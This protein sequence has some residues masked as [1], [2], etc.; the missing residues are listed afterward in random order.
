MIELIDV[1]AAP[2][3][4]TCFTTRAGGVSTGPW[5]GLNLGAATG[6]DPADVRENR[7]RLSAALG[8]DPDS[9]AL[10]RQVHGTDVL[11]V[12]VPTLP[13]GFT[14]ALVGWPDGDAMVTD[15]PGIAL[16]VLGADCLPVLLWRRD[17]PRVAAAH[18]GWRGLVGGVLA[19]AVA[20]LGEP[21][22]IGAALGPGIGPCCYP[23]D[24]ALRR[25]FAERFGPGAVDG[26]AVNLA[27]AACADLEAAGVSGDAIHHVGACTSCEPERFFSYRRD[28]AATGRQGGVV[29]IEEAA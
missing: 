26:D 5:R 15:Q 12:D 20:A 7:R 28:G 3:I 13:G 19:N 6:D 8:A 22:R 25:R 27:A 11:H 18:A 4:R 23:V 2:G 10:V 14:G 21:G 17:I 24:G 29:M 9:V 16:V 1:P